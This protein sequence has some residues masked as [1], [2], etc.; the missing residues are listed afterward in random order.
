[1]LWRE[2]KFSKYKSRVN[3]RS[4]SFDNLKPIFSTSAG[5]CFTYFLHT[6]EC[7]M[8]IFISIFY[9]FVL[10]LNPGLIYDVHKHDQTYCANTHKKKY[11]RPKLFYSS[12]NYYCI[13]LY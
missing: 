4:F 5:T 9:G 7:M 13:H 3:R 11:I 6:Y 12:S 8:I 1:M 10:H 2:N